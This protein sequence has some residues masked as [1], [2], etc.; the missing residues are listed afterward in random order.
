MMERKHS[1]ER[2][3]G[4]LGISAYSF[5]FVPKYIQFYLLQFFRFGNRVVRQISHPRLV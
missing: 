3:D 4:Y 2:D 5:G 1:P